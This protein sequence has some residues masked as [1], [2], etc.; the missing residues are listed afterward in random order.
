MHTSL[1]QK[2]LDKDNALRNVITLWSPQ[3]QQTGSTSK[4]DTQPV[5]FHSNRNGYVFLF[6]E[7]KDGKQKW[8]AY[9]LSIISK[10]S[11]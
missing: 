8:I 10:S 4:S 3:P 6:L 11:I 9:I 2:Q 5:K 7:L 1:K